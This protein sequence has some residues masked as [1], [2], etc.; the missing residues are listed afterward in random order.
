MIPDPPLPPFP[1]Y[2][3][4]FFISKNMVLLNDDVKIVSPPETKLKFE[5]EREKSLKL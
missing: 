4:I 2:P 5:M 1:I 3:L